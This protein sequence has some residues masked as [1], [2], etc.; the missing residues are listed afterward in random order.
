MSTV[1]G[2]YHLIFYTDIWSEK[3]AMQM[4]SSKVQFSVRKETPDKVDIWPGSN[5]A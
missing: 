4:Y 5:I 3:I 2:N 1:V